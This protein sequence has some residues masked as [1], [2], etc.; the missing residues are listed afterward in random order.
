[1]FNSL[2][3]RPH[4][5]AAQP[6]FSLSKTPPLKPPKKTRPTTPKTEPPHVSKVEGSLDQLHPSVADLARLGIGL[7]PPKKED[8]QRLID[9]H[10]NQI[11]SRQNQPQ[12][13]P[14]CGGWHE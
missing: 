13:P 1:M 11:P 14:P 6:P 5:G 4:P 2:A 3:G 12:E 8:L 10:K 9:N 7:L